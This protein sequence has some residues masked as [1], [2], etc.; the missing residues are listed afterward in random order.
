MQHYL[1]FDGK[2]I[3]ELIVT[4]FEAW[5]WPWTSANEAAAAQTGLRDAKP[6]TPLKTRRSRTDSKN[7]IHRFYFLSFKFQNR[8]CLPF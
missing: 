7:T 5:P 6:E 1:Y 2:Q 4:T 3:H 8:D